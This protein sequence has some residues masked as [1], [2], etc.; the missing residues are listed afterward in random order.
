[1]IPTTIRTDE[2]VFK[3]ETKD[4]YYLCNKEHL[5]EVQ[6]GTIFQLTEL[7]F[8]FIGMVKKS[9]K[10]KGF[11]LDTY[12]VDSKHI[13]IKFEKEGVINTVKKDLIELEGVLKPYGYSLND[14]KL[15][16][17]NFGNLEKIFK[18]WLYNGTKPK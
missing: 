10:E 7:G 12:A 6:K 1:M 5:K 18:K 14:L 13:I 16:F 9:Y 4:S 2:P 8:K 15:Y 17:V 11:I 3:V